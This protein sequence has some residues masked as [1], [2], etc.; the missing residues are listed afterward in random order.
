MNE[1]FSAPNFRVKFGRTAWAD[2]DPSETP[3]V[4]AAL[5]STYCAWIF[6]MSK[7]SE[8]LEN[9]RRATSRTQS[10]GTG[11]IRRKAGAPGEDYLTGSREGLSDRDIGR[12][13]GIHYNVVSKWRR[14]FSQR[15]V[16]TLQDEPR[17]CSG[18]FAR[19]HRPSSS[20]PARHGRWS[21]RL[22]A[23]ELGVSKTTVQR[24][25]SHNQIKTYLNLK[26]TFKLSTDPVREGCTYLQ[27]I[28]VKLRADRRELKTCGSASKLIPGLGLFI[29]KT[30]GHLTSWRIPGFAPSHWA[31]IP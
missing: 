5:P 15:G 25:W 26:R 4:G 14:R 23:R 16:G 12:K 10:D 3:F 24:M 22:M 31:E 17:S 20:G 9:Q 27:Q 11:T 28:R 29:P 8:E 19:D 6:C 30:S 7:G 2:R 21:C 1:T 18:D 13:V